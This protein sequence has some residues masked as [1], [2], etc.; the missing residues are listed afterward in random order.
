MKTRQRLFS[1]P[2]TAGLL[3]LLALGLSPG[4]RSATP[5]AGSIS[6]AA[7]TVNVDFAPVV[8]GTYTD[9]GIQN[10]CPTLV[11]DNFDVTV[12]LPQAASTFY[13]ANTAKLSIHYTFTSTVDS[14]LDIFAISPNG[15]SH[16]PGAHDITATGVNYEDLVVTDPVAG[17]WHV[18]SVASL[19][20]L[21]V[22]AHAT[23]TMTV[24]PRPTVAPPPGPSA[25]AYTVYPAPENIPPALGSSNA[26]QHGAGE[27]SIGV[28]WKTGAAMYQAGNHTLRVLFDDTRIPATASWAD[29]RSPYARV[30]LDPI[31]WTDSTLGRT[32]ESQLIG[33]CSVTSYTD[34][35]GETWNASQGCGLPAGA[36]HQTIGGGNYAAPSPVVHTAPHS[37][38]YCSQDIAAAICARS[39]DGGVTFGPGIPIYNLNQ[40]G[41]LHG[42][43]EIS[44]DGTA[45]VPNRNCGT[46]QAVVTSIDNG[47]TWLVK[48]IPDSSAARAGGDP[49]VGLGA[50]NTLYFGYTDVDG[51]AKMAVSRDHGDHFTRSVDLGTPFGIQNADFPEVI[52]GDDDRAAFAFLG[53]QTPG[54][55]QSSDFTGVWHLYSAHTYDGGLTWATND[56]TPA[57]PVQRGCIWNGGGS[58]QCRNLLD[59]ND[60]T[61]DK[62]GHVLVGYADGCTGA[63]VTDPTKNTYDALATIARQS[64]G[65]GLFAAYDPA[66]GNGYGDVCQ[67]TTAQGITGGNSCRNDNR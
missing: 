6:T 16:G 64:G 33:A 7:P 45:Y 9:V 29:K 12:V 36:D 21:P 15:A 66:N 20:P 55:P 2:S 26:G 62:T 28:N 47:L 35:D 34:D 27:P 18:R 23:I 10:T 22:G 44:P 56:L 58:N 11:C 25:Q 57:D 30:S 38:Y 53:T 50:K 4:A 39:D 49:A 31:L 61:L 40:C 60:I 51:H 54:D 17:V 52:A 46:H 14:D 3:A 32:F 5:A 43:V 65:K 42:H 59:F 41:G 1:V 67:G 24:A 48:P 8:A 19:S 13:A 37:V 63:C